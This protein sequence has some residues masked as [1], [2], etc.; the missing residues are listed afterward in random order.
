MFATIPQPF[1]RVQGVKDE[2]L[3]EEVVVDQP[4]DRPSLHGK[5]ASGRRLVAQT[6]GW[7]DLPDPFR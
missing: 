3:V 7:E 4:R 5:G 6:P 1:G 2:V